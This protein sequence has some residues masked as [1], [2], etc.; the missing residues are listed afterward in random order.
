MN[1]EVLNNKNKNSYRQAVF[2]IEIET[3]RMTNPNLKNLPEIKNAGN[4][5]SRCKDIKS[6]KNNDLNI[7]I[8]F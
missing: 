1:K 3:A 5:Y 4:C 6:T 7:N 2:D 8:N